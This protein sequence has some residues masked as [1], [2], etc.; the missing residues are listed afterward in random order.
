LTLAL[1]TDRKSDQY[2]RLVYALFRPPEKGPIKLVD[3]RLANWVYDLDPDDHEEATEV[4][5]A[6]IIQRLKELF[7]RHGAQETYLPTLMPETRLLDL[8]PADRPVRL[9]DTDGKLVQLVE[10]DLIAMARSVPRR[11]VGR[12]KRFHLGMQHSQFAPG[13]HPLRAAE[14]RLV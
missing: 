9:L 8:Y 7:R 1:T 2:R 4:W 11:H 5:S 10:C 14:L 13:R 12:R 6:V 3:E